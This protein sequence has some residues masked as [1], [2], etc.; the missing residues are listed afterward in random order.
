MVIACDIAPELCALDMFQASL[1]PLPCLIA[2]VDDV[3]YLCILIALHVKQITLLLTRTQT[4]FENIARLIGT[5]GLRAMPDAVMQKGDG[6][7]LRNELALADNVLV[8]SN[9]VVIHFP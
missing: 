2:S 1:V 5:I 7:R 3:R 4:Q 9:A 6:T 8:A